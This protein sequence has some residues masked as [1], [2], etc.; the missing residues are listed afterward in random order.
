MQEHCLLTHRIAS[1]RWTQVMQ[2]DAWS[3]P[4]RCIRIWAASPPRPSITYRLQKYTRAILSTLDRPLYITKLQQT[5][6][7]AKSRKPAPID[8]YWRWPNMLPWMAISRRYF[9]CYIF[10]LYSNLFHLHLLPVCRNLRKS[11]LFLHRISTVE[12]FRKRALFPSRSVPPVYRH[13]R[14]RKCGEK[15]RRRFSQ[16]HRIAWV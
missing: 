15:I 8:V 1:K 12:I 4:L 7:R 13:D 6:I 14:L 3:G 10:V 5:T 9:S 16:I 11:W 2:S